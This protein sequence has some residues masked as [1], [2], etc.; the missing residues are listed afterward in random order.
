MSKPAKGY[1]KYSYEKL[2]YCIRNNFSLTHLYFA[3]YITNIN[4]IYLLHINII[5]KGGK[6]KYIR[7]E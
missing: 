4:N 5:R 3:S 6:A 7:F 2:N 1:D